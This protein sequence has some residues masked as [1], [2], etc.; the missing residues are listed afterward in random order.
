MK[1]LPKISILRQLRIV[2]CSKF[3]K[4]HILSILPVITNLTE[5]EIDSIDLGEDNN[6]TPFNTFSTQLFLNCPNLDS[7][8]FR[9]CPGINSDFINFLIRAHGGTY[10]RNDIYR[11]FLE[12]VEI[13]NPETL[14]NVEKKLKKLNL[15][16]FLRIE[17]SIQDIVRFAPFLCSLT[18]SRIAGFSDR[19]ILSIMESLTSLAFLELDNCGFGDGENEQERITDIG[20]R[21]IRLKAPKCLK[22]L[23]L[24]NV[25]GC[26]ES[27]GS[28]LGTRVKDIPKD[29]VLRDESVP[30]LGLETLSLSGFQRINNIESQEKL[31]ALPLMW[32]GATLGDGFIEKI[33]EHRMSESLQYRTTIMDS[34]YSYLMWIFFG[35]GSGT[36]SD[37]GENIDGNYEPIF[38]RDL[39][40]F[41][42]KSMEDDA[43]WFAPNMKNLKI[44]NSSGIQPSLIARFLENWSGSLKSMTLLGT[45]QSADL[46]LVRLCYSF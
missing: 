10:T 27:I 39:S 29:K 13:E 18:L 4:K 5:I 43:L 34:A 40:S 17:H 36:D 44:L 12:Q 46:E 42:N 30:L 8:N 24:H 38:D 31:K 26:V 20:M 33:F 1:S 19:H 6:L 7:I 2:R 11:L 21:L 16:N 22:Q 32:S 14:K 9:N 37:V 23:R 3:L 28:L 25:W 35:N 41:F 45:Q 15:G